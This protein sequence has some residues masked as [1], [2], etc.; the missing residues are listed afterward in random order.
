MV[1]NILATLLALIGAE[2]AVWSPFLPWYGGRHGSDIRMD[3][4]F[5]SVGVTPHHA[6]L[7]GSLFLPMGF[8]A[9]L[10][11]LGI[12]TRSRLVTAPAGILVLGMTVLWMVRQAQ[13]SHAL[14][15]GGNGLDTGVA[16]ALAG[17]LM[18]FAA[19]S[20]LPSR[21]PRPLA[22]PPALYD[23]VVP[24]DP[25]VSDGPAV[26]YDRPVSY[27]SAIPY[28]PAVSYSPAVPYD[29]EAGYGSAIPD[30]PPHPYGSS[31]SWAASDDGEPTLIGEPTIKGAT[32]PPAAPRDADPPP[33]G[34]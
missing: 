11:L 6:P 2:A 10:T 28:N 1:R 15:A 27:E 5:T 8:A 17:A 4:L 18:L 22:E 30:D 3:D 14:T 32:L 20:L 16:T 7:L 23:S 19:V 29:S 24:Y 34:T 26:P 21:R 12:L 13:F 33:A 9:L 31:G 25:D